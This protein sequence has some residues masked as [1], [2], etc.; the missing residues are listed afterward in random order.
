VVF[1]Q[2]ARLFAYALAGVLLLGPSA[3]SESS[4]APNWS[5]QVLPDLGG[6]RHAT[7][8]RNRAGVVFLGEEKLLAYGV[9]L[10]T[11]RLSSRKSPEISSP[12]RL[13]V[14]VLDAGS[15]KLTLTKD[16]GTR[17]HDSD[18]QATAG[19]IL[20]RTGAVVKLYSPD[21]TEAH[22]LDIPLQKDEW[23]STSVSPTGKTILVNRLNQRLI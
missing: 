19:G 10:N 22:D 4:E 2:A 12:F 9:E 7:F 15:G 1:L 20:V 21:F 16:F 8:D 11:T 18:V 14:W 3:R 5:Q 23:I 17:A 6:A 13:R